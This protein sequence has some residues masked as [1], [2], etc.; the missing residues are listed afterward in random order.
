V[1]PGISTPLLGKLALWVA[2]VLTLWSMFHYLKLAAPHLQEPARTLPA[3]RPK[4]PTIDPAGRET[5]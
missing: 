2:S 3:A 1:L 5:L 4:S